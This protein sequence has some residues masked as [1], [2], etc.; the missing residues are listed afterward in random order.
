MAW[1]SFL[2]LI[3]QWAE[4]FKIRG[5][6]FPFQSKLSHKRTS[7]AQLPKWSSICMSYVFWN[8]FTHRSS[9]IHTVMVCF[10][11]NCR[12]IFMQWSIKKGT[13]KFTWEHSKRL[14]RMS[15]QLKLSFL[16]TTS[17]LLSFINTLHKMKK[18]NLPSFFITFWFCVLILDFCMISNFDL[19]F[20]LR[21]LISIFSHR[22]MVVSITELTIRSKSGVTREG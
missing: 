12:Y 21:P 1:I 11:Q 4:A 14:F 15:L 18:I 3:F 8:V 17:H 2:I 10:Q 16:L 9:N 6:L 19:V 20:H 5:F 7:R 22:I 13:S